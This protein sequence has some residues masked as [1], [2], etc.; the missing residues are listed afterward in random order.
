MNTQTYTAF[1][2][3]LAKLAEAAGS[4]HR[5][6]KKLC[7]ELD[8]HGVLSGTGHKRISIPKTV[9]SEKDLRDLGFVSVLIAVPESG[10]SSFR[11][12]RHP[13][14]NYHLHEHGDHW[15]MHKDDHASS[16]MLV[17]KL[18][19]EDRKGSGS[20]KSGKPKN[21]AQIAGQAA[22]EFLRGTPHIVTEGIPGM[23]YYARG[24]IVKTP[25]MA[26]RLAVELPRE[27]F[28]RIRRWRPTKEA[29]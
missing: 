12:F 27:Y 2:S 4:V 21:S 13:D 7:E 8:T 24:K 28:H 19:M 18:F 16:T 5:R 11:S 9:L 23:Y 26:E 10:Q 20:K 3:E 6:F 14:N 29:S 17:R 15:T 22:L 1:F 25:G